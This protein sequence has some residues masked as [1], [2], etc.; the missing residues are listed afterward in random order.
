M[1]DELE[2]PPCPL[3]G[4][5][6]FR[7][8]IDAA[9][10]RLTGKRGTFQV[11]ACTGCGLVVTRPRPTAAALAYYYE[12]AYSSSTGTHCVE[13]IQTRWWLR[14]ITGY[15]LRVVERAHPL[16]PG[17]RL[18]DVGCGYGAFLSRAR[19][20]TGCDATGV[21]TDAGSIAR[22]LDRDLI[23]YRCASVESAGLEPGQFDV[24]TFFESLEHHLDP[25]AALK[26]ARKLLKPGGV[27]V[28][29][30]PNFDGVWRRVFGSW[31]MPL[32]V[33]QHLVHFTPATLRQALRAA[34]FEVIGP[35]RA[36]FYPLESTASLGLWLNRVL[37][38][39]IRGYRLRWTRPD[40][41]LLLLVLCIWWLVIELPTQDLLAATGL[42]GHQ[43]MVATPG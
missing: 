2:S 33:P 20:E 37:G 43:L 16:G 35:H 3:C 17:Q 24:I 23:D 14:W 26:A 21:D 22:A 7:P 13:A 8:V 1:L 12:G 28:V 40:G 11:Q 5:G 9:C 15:R 38:R 10:D 34:G 29:E 25:V 41:A 27:C 6:V 32:L 31:W 36:M 4:G 19:R 39:P 30:V 42:T 18:L